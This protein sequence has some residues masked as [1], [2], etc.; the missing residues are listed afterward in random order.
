MPG[1]REASHA[2]ARRA[3]ETGV[4]SPSQ[5]DPVEAATASSAASACGPVLP[6]K[7]TRNDGGRQAGLA[8]VYKLCQSVRRGFLRFNGAEL[9]QDVM[10]GVK[11]EDG[12]N[13]LAA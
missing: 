6:R 1:A 12:I 4:L 5:A 8:M 10:A 7:E 3:G 11:Y 2:I 9:F 13:K